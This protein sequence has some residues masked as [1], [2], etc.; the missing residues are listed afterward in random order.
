MSDQAQAA[1]AAAAD[2]IPA[3]AL[4]PAAE[5][6][7]LARLGSFHATRL[8]FVRTLIRRMAREHWTIDRARFELDDDGF[9]VA[10]YTVTTPAGPLNF[11]AFS[12]YLDPE[13]RTDRV[14][15]TRWDAAFSL[16]REALGDALIERLRGNTPRQEAGR[17]GP[18]DLVL[19]RANKSVRMFESV[20][21]A[22]ATGRQPDP[23]A[24]LDAGYL[25]RTT[26]VYGNGKGG[27][28]D[29][30]RV[31]QS[32]IFTLPYQAE[33]LVV[34]LA[35]HFSLD[36]LN[37]VAKCRNP[38][39]AVALDRRLA[40]CF[41][42]GNATGLGM[43]PFLAN[44]PKLL[45]RWIGARELALA[46]VRAVRA[47]TPVKRARYAALLDRALAHVRQWRTA[48]TRQAE[49]IRLL[50]TELADFRARD[51]PARD[52]W[53]WVVR[54][55]DRYL[56]LETAELLNSVLIELYPELVDE[57]ENSTGDDEREELAPHMT[58]G[59]LKSMVERDYGWALAI[60]FS[61]AG[62]EHFFWYWSAE[63]LEPRIGV[64]NRE[65]GADKEMRVDIARQ[66]W[67]L[68]RTLA[69]LDEAGL[70]RSVAEFLVAA[71]HWRWIVRRIQSLS[72]RRYAEIHDNTLSSDCLPIDLLRCKLSIFGA[73]KFD[74][75]SDR[76]TR[77]TLCQGAPL[78]DELDSGDAD[79][80]CFPVIPDA[81]DG[82][83]R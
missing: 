25:M 11:L 61:A 31:R 71:P 42:V 75:K 38:R 16:T 34:Y 33:M 46:R 43:A 80:W 76:W 70:A 15:A 66:V 57:L 78:A 55:A 9:G 39:R 36:L 23:S 35:R 40:R 60:D 8:S 37:H 26:A 67:R 10:V 53:D 50:D 77:I 56:S 73:T 14:I 45:D 18:D 79:D 6:M 69:E 74:P 7:R 24:I 21:G 27:M 83:A 82:A 30:A 81:L 41:G 51:L 48:D 49:R 65:P 44:H 2:S 64:R 68:H 28:A 62:A 59:A 58:L 5:V 1:T 12:N 29:W 19:S 20:A 32:G 13:D 17:F 63:K 47:A 52:P 72:E 4:R 22:L 54:R 3:L